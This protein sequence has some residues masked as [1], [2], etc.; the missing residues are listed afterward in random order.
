MIPVTAFDLK[1]I[2]RLDQVARSLAR[3]LER[4]TGV[5]M[6]EWADSLIEWDYREARRALLQELR[7]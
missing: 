4:A 3:C 7:G 2:Y 1:D 6:G 5:S